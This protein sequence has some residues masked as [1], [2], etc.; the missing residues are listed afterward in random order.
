MN[1]G[2]HNPIDGSPARLLPGSLN[3]RR[4]D[5]LLVSSRPHRRWV[6]PVRRF[7]L[8]A[9]M[10]LAVVLIMTDVA[11]DSVWAAW[12]PPVLIT[13][14]LA[15]SFWLGHLIRR[16][17]QQHERMV[18]AMQAQQWDEA[19]RQVSRLLSR[20]VDSLEIRASAL[21]CLASL[22]SRAGM[23]ESAVRICDEVLSQPAPPTQHQVTLVEKSLAL[24]RADRLTDATELLDKLR[25]ADL[26][27][28]PAVWADVGR[29]YRRIRTGNFAGAAEG[30]DD[31]ARRARGAFPRQAAYV[32]GLVAL[33]FA[34][35]GQLDR[36]QAY[37]RCATLLIEP[38]EL[39][40]PFR[41]LA[42]LSRRL[43]P[44]RSPL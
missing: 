11:G 1:E 9:V 38:E 10:V 17:H 28:A 37:Y 24:L 20:P 8:M 4:I 44:A 40:V 30:A 21:V 14:A 12:A 7:G 2:T 35:L 36:A 34:E 32:Y 6:W 29:L 27:G 22:A 3:E 43:A 23:H 41:E 5:G 26:S 18:L 39:A 16:V 25:T 13:A 15:A 42:E 33:V 19:A 31:L